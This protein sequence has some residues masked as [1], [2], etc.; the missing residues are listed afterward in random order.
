M[1]HQE[2]QDKI[3]QIYK[4]I[5]KLKE[6]SS[7]KK[8]EWL[9][10]IWNRE[11][12]LVESLMENFL[13]NVEQTQYATKILKILRQLLEFVPEIVY[14]QYMECKTLPVAIISYIKITK[15]Q[16][17]T[18]DAFFLFKE[19]FHESSYIELL[20]ER[21]LAEKLMDTLIVINKSEYFDSICDILLYRFHNLCPPSDAEPQSE[22]CTYFLDL[23]TTHKAGYLFIETAIHLLNRRGAEGERTVNCL[24][25]IVR[26]EKTFEKMYSNDKDLLVD[27]IED[28]ID[29]DMQ[30]G[31]REALVN[32]LYQLI[33]KGGCENKLDT[34]RD[35]WR[36]LNFDPDTLTEKAKELVASLL[37]ICN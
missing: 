24:T 12:G 11:Y 25:W 10:K 4:V 19:F 21:D 15:I 5:K 14:E 23:L 13:D 9:M 31:Q 20:K 2:I 3:D 33:S 8:I 18:P 32:L 17:M 16:D 35:I 34:A 30:N 22:E 28:T 37:S 27:I 36:K 7:K 26:Y 29:K 6:K 1:E